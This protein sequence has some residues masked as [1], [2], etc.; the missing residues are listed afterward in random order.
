MTLSDFSLLLDEGVAW[1]ADAGVQLQSDSSRPQRSQKRGP[2]PEVSHGPGTK[3]R[4]RLQ[5]LGEQD[6]GQPEVDQTR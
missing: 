4:S 6:G 1:I 3:S 2:E 5:Q